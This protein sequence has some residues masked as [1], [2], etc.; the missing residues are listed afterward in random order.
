MEFSGSPARQGEARLS[1]FRPG[2]RSLG[3]ALD[4]LLLRERLD[5]PELLDSEAVDG[6]TLKRSYRELQRL[7]LWLGNTAA[8]LDRLRAGGR[9][10]KVLDIGCAQ[11]ALLAVIRE[12]LGHEGIGFDLR[13][14]PVDASIPIVEGNAVTDALPRADV[15]LS[16]VMA[17]HLD[18]RELK[19]M[20]VNVSRSADRLI[21]LDLVRHRVPLTLFRLF[22]APLLSRI[23]A[24]DGATSIRRA[25]TRV[26]LGAIFAEAIKESGRPVERLTHHVATLW[27]RQIVDVQWSKRTER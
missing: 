10:L 25:F 16:V 27:T 2:G 21:L 8:I 9:R 7:H 15:A 26:E 17:H 11:G 14:M 6:E 13:S 23:N 24:L 1:G 3:E 5:K 19:A 18:R 4:S 12:R 22:V 20:I